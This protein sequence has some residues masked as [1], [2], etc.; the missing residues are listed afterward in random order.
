MA[1]SANQL[2]NKAQRLIKR[3]DSEKARQLLNEVLRMFPQNKK[4][5][6]ELAR[7]M[8]G[9]EPKSLNT[10]KQQFGVLLESYKQGLYR[11]VL[12]G[13]ERLLSKAP[14]SPQLLNLIGASHLALGQAE[15]AIAFF[16]LAA[17]ANPNY[18]DA[19]NNLGNALLIVGRFDDALTH[20]LAAQALTDTSP[21]ILFNLGNVYRKLGSL[22]K[23]VE[24]YMRA[25]SMQPE[26]LDARNSLA[27]T[28]SQLGRVEEALKHQLL[29]LQSRTDD[30][31]YWQS[32]ASLLSTMIFDSYDNVLAD[33][34]SQLLS[35]RSDVRPWI[36]SSAVSSILKNHPNISEALNF[37]Q[38]GQ[39]QDLIKDPMDI[40]STLLS[41]VA[42]VRL[43]LQF[44]CVAPIPDLALEQLLRSLRFCFLLSLTR[45]AP[46]SSDCLELL[47]ALGC[48]SFLNEY[49]YGETEHETLLIETLKSRVNALLE[50]EARVSP[51]VITCLAAY[52]PIANFA[53]DAQVEGLQK[54][55]GNLYEMYVTSRYQEAQ[56]GKTIPVLAE[57]TDD[58]SKK[59]QAQYERNPY[60]R[61]QL[62]STPAKPK[63]IVDL[64]RDIPL[65]LSYSQASRFSRPD[66]LVAGCG[67][68]QHA[69]STALRYEG[70]RVLAMDLSRQSLSY[71]IRKARELCIDNIEFIQGDLLA[72]DHLDKKFDIIECSGVLHHLANPIAGWQQ[73]H[74]CLKPRGLMKIGLYSVQARKPVNV[75]RRLIS[76]L[77]LQPIYADIVHFRQMVIEAEGYLKDQLQP[78]VRYRDFYSTSEFRDLVF[79]TQEQQFTLKQI[80]EILPQLEFTFLGFEL[81]RMN[82][83]SDF[84]D[85]YFNP[86]DIFDLFKWNEYENVNPDCFRGMYQFWVQSTRTI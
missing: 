30:S 64:A 16:K 1:V 77:N 45:D 78:L 66:V 82:M 10:L 15:E 85:I 59:V 2:L 42:S 49:V 54:Q 37:F 46:I 79:H 69:I 86:E 32:F 51:E 9:I 58:T 73:L 11:D 22:D 17:K 35:R 7:L 25:L 21:Q 65:N 56:L 8:E 18:V 60:P 29:V 81:S 14:N 31:E 57:I 27:V 26:Y 38:S 6:I 20:L 44:M 47:A 74:K 28:L 52:R 63:T 55:M 72:L 36:I 24:I 23:A 76:D 12:I 67:T 71:A 50:Q 43:L 62:T 34:V 41:G 13:G 40:P 33:K 48:Q 68:G 70:G 80:A 3:G 61:W 83:L 19:T 75:A 4:A 39:A 53:T 5:K 84:K